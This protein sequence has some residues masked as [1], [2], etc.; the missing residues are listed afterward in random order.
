MDT[1]WTRADTWAAL[2][3]G[4]REIFEPDAEQVSIVGDP[5]GT[6]RGGVGLDDDELFDWMSE[7]ADLVEDH[8]I[9]G[10]TYRLDVWR[11][12]RW[13]ALI[14]PGV[15]GASPLGR[16]VVLVPGAVPAPFRVQPATLARPTATN[17]L[18][19]IRQAIAAGVEDATPADEA[20]VVAAEQ[21]LGV[22]FP[23]ELRALWAG[24]GSG[25]YL[26][27]EVGRD[28]DDIDEDAVAFDIVSP[29][30]VAREVTPWREGGRE[31]TW[32]YD[33]TVVLDPSPGD[34]VQ[35]VMHSHGWVPF[36]GDWGGNPYALDLTPGPAG[37][38]GQV[39]Q[40][41]HERDDEPPRLV[42]DSLTD[43]VQGR[44][45]DEERAGSDVVRKA[46]LGSSSA[47]T[48]DQLATAHDL[49]VLAVSAASGPLD[50]TPV[51]SL[52]RL[53]SVTAQT[54]SL[55]DPAQLRALPALEYLQ[56]GADDW[57]RLLDSGPLP[58]TLLAA[59][60]PADEVDTAAGDGVQA[61]LR[62]AAGLAPVERIELAGTL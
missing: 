31:I 21:A 5:D 28:E 12:G 19:V 1:Y 33:A 27:G 61:R 55:A 34:K 36:A 40:A 38:V 57:N 46:S 15:D 62:E 43:F 44:F 39:I 6:V 26:P 11:D 54:G 53:R 59:G 29:E 41:D 9:D 37:L 47:P 50:L 4:L 58:R 48:V 17:D 14:T 16:T 22:A 13:A 52:P 45:V 8:L 24:A 49:E 35:Q 30:Q 56:L 60:L 25:D 18:E 7:V 42:S 23:P 51:L 20:A 32:E 3:R 2:A 10:M